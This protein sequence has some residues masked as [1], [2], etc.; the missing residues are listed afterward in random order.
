[1]QQQFVHGF[2]MKIGGK[3]DAETLAMISEQLTIYAGGFDIAKRNTDLMR[4]D[5]FPDCA[6]AY[7]A[8]RKIE[9]MAETTVKEYYT[10]LRCFFEYVA[11]PYDEIK[12]A[13]VM[14]Y[15]YAQECSDRTKAHRLTVIKTFYE[16]AVNEDYI[17]KSPCKTIKAIKYQ[18]K[19]PQHLT[20]MELE[21]LRNACRTERERAIVEFFYST[22]CRVSE[23][24]NLKK[25]DLNLETG[26]VKLLGKGNKERIDYLNPK[27][28]VALKKYFLTRSDNGEYVFA[29]MREPF[30]KVCPTSL[31]NLFFEL[32]QRAG[33]EKRV[34]PHLM[35]HTNATLALEKGMPIEEVQRMLGHSKID[36]TLQ[37]AEVAD[38]SV[39]RNHQRCVI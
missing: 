5:D 6:K 10:I 26:E 33:I 32:G 7:L 35:R 12:K 28:V 38:A 25:S 21:L 14:R 18:K 20:D 19:A 8:T 4:R 13:D 23:A 9:G 2:L 37:Y 15:L 3:V 22:G 31:Q 27:T 30:G 34:H 24:C 36:T 39:K 16:W 29:I 11:L 17:E 1:M